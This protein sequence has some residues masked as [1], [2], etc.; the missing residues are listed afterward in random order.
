MPSH[1]DFF[2]GIGGRRPPLCGIVGPPSQA[3]VGVLV[4]FD[5]YR[6]RGAVER[7]Q[8]FCATRQSAR[9]PARD[10]KRASRQCQKEPRW[11][12]PYK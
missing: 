7:V 5:P 11:S 6:Q 9:R 1:R 2:R 10:R 12:L 4:L 8:S 3:L